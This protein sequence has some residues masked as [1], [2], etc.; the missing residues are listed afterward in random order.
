MSKLEVYNA[1]TSIKHNFQDV[2]KQPKERGKPDERSI[3]QSYSRLPKSPVITKTKNED[4][5][6]ITIKTRVGKSHKITK[7]AVKLKVDK[8]QYKSI[9]KETLFTCLTNSLDSLEVSLE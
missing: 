6:D 4:T 3:R 2:T 1:V 9:N 8:D 5:A 7:V